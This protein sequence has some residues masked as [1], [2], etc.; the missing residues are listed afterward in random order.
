MLEGP[1]DSSGIADPTGQ[2]QRVGEPLLGVAYPTGGVFQQAQLAQGRGDQPVTAGAL[3]LFQGGDERGC[4]FVVPALFVP[5][6]AEDAVRGC[7]QL[8]RGDPQSGP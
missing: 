4:G 7:P 8:G 2:G 5:K 3:S 1:A 6:I